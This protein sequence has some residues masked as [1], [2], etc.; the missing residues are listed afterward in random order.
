[1]IE[2]GTEKCILIP[3]LNRKRQTLEFIREWILPR[4]HII[5]DQWAV[6][7]FLSNDSVYLYGNINHSENFVDPEDRK[8]HTQSI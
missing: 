6:Y 8:I 1:M 5:S 3:V 2:R 4:T 7:S